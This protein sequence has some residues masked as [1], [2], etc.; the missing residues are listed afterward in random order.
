MVQ[1]CSVGVPDEKNTENGSDSRPLTYAE[2]L[3]RV[4]RVLLFLFIAHSLSRNFSDISHCLEIT[5]TSVTCD[6][7]AG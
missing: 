2:L 5:L 7:T 4:L 6:V 1:S 3:P